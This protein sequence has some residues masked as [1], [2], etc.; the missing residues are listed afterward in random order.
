MVNRKGEVRE[1]PGEEEG[2]E[3]YYSPL[4]HGS[5][6][7]EEALSAGKKQ[8]IA[9][10]LEL[11][12]GLGQGSYPL[13]TYVGYKVQVYEYMGI[14]EGTVLYTY[15]TLPLRNTPRN[16]LQYLF[17]FNLYLTHRGSVQ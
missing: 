8:L 5:A 11:R 14:W 16:T 3:E 4:L 9:R 17:T 2:E 7:Q 15:C 12:L 10:G 13:R 6:L 1:R